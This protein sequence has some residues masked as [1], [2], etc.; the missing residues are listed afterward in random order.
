MRKRTE[1]RKQLLST[2]VEARRAVIQSQ[3]VSLECKLQDS[4]K[5]QD[6]NE[7]K[8]ALE[9]INKN[10]KYFYSY[11]KRKCKVR[12]KIG[13]LMDKDGNHTNDRKCMADILS[14]QLKAAFSAPSLAAHNT[15]EEQPSAQV[16]NDISFSEEDIKKAIDELSLNSAP[17]PDRFPAVML[18]NCKEE[19][20]KPLYLIWR[21]SLDR[22]EV[23]VI[24]KT[25]AITPIYKGNDKKFPCNY[26]PVALTSL[27]V[28]VF[29]KVLRKSV[30]FANIDLTYVNFIPN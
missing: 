17:G 20:C 13:P 19:L 28:K 9:A 18:K 8:R 2:D 16:L 15:A 22:G 30:G 5:A 4:Y 12:S 24:L 3:L 6:E 23:P 1:L 27:L 29:E 25:S 10:P 21:T 26:R 14:D 7:E 11:A